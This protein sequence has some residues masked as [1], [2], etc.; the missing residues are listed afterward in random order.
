METE[1]IGNFL[2]LNSGF[3]SLS[4]VIF[5]LENHTDRGAWQVTVHWVTRIRHDLATKP[6][7]YTHTHTYTYIYI[8]TDIYTYIQIYI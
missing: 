1:I 8:H 2:T 3:V 4:V 7:F 5:L 6:P